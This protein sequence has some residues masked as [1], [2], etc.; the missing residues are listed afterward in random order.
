MSQS[1][2]SALYTVLG[3]ASVGLMIVRVDSGGLPRALHHHI[4][5]FRVALMVGI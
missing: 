4:I 5:E 1:A 3:A 2:A